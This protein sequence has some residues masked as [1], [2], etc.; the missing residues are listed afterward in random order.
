MN[1]SY[2]SVYNEAIGAWVAVSEIPRSARWGSNASGSG[3]SAEIRAHGGVKKILLALATI[4]SYS[5]TTA[6]AACTTADGGITYTCS[7]ITTTAQTLPTSTSGSTVTIDSS[8]VNSSV[9]TGSSVK[10]N[11][12]ATGDITVT[13]AQGATNYS[14]MQGIYLGS[15]TATSGNLL[16]V[17]AGN[18]TSTTNTGIT[19]Q[20][21][22]AGTTGSAVIE[23]L[24]TGVISGNTYGIVS[25]SQSTG[26]IAIKTAGSVTGTNNDG[27]MA[28]IGNAASAGTLTVNQ[29]A[30]S[31]TGNTD[32]ILVSNQGSGATTVTTAGSVAATNMSAYG[33]IN[34]SS[35]GTLTINQTGSSI[36]G[37]TGINAQAN[38]GSSGAIVVNQS[39]SGTVTGSNTGINAQS[40]GSGDISITTAG[41]VASSSSSA[42][43]AQNGASSGAIYVTQNGGAITTGRN[44]GV[45]VMAFGNGPVNVAQNAGQITG[46]ASGTGISVYNMGMASATTVTSHGDVSAG[47]GGIQVI[48]MGDVSV[49]TSGNVTGTNAYSRGVNATSYYGA[50]VVTQTSGTIT[51]GMSGINTYSTNAPTTITTAGAVNGGTYG[52]QAL[53]VGSSAVPAITINQTAGSITGTGGF[54]IYALNYAF[55]SGATFAPVALNIAGT[56]TGGT[57]PA[58]SAQPGYI[59]AGIFLDTFAGTPVTIDLQSGANVSATSGIAI[60][61]NDGDATVTFESGSKV[62][63][64]VLLGNGND[65]LTIKGTADISGATLLDGGNSTTPNVSNLLGMTIPVTDTLG[66]PTAG[67]NKL[68]F[69][70]T[71][72]SLAGSVMKNWE[73]VTL[74]GSAVTFAGDAAL[75][76]GTGTNPD[77]SLQGLVLKN[78]STLT[79]PMALAV[80]GDVAIDASS[81]LKHSV[82][83]QIT[84]NV[85]NAGLI[86]W[87][88]LGQTLTV[89]GN[90]TGISG[91]KLSLETFFG[92]DSS[93]TDKLAIDGG[94]A[95]GTT[96]L[97]IRRAGGNGAQTTQGIRVVQTL[98]GATTNPTAFTLSSL[99][100]G[101]RVGVGSIVAG[102]YDYSL[103]RGGVGGVANDWYLTSIGNQCSSNSALCPAV[104][105]GAPVA[106]KPALRPEVGSYLNNRLFAQTMQFHSLHERQGQAPGLISNNLNQGSDANVWVRL[107]G[108]TSGRSGA[109]GMDLSD[110]SYLVHAGGDVLRMKGGRDGSVRV[111]VMAAYGSGNNQASNGRLSSRGTV[112]GYNA[113]LYGT[114]YGNRDILSG[115]Y[116]DS[117][118]MFGTF[119]NKVSGQ[120]LPTE[121]YNARNLAA[122]LEGGYS[123]P[124]HDDGTNRMFLEPQAQVIVSNYRADVH[125]EQNGTVVSGQSGTSVTTRLGL[126]LHSDVKD[127]IG[128]GQMRPFAEVNWW[129]GPGSQSV[130]FDGAAIRDD[131]PANRLEG[132]VGLQGNLTKAISVWGT[133]GFEVGARDYTAGKV[134][135]GVKYSW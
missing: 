116:V 26:N 93:P 108:K 120:G 95:S 69:Q 48:G 59:G 68:T 38:P 32:G 112:D 79:S 110:T 42:I 65:T 84:G 85:T 117:W 49:T 51:A 75:V 67:T 131:L 35:N 61:K 70:G 54:G 115:P 34:A 99:S 109:D 77:G 94:N 53:V 5:A 39:T 126:R 78:A 128:M 19:V 24:S 3:A 60:Q 7:G 81:T 127:R 87:G 106:T 122:S 57:L 41:S 45:N 31:I 86:Y 29:T 66:T 30:G 13:Q 4:G 71:T 74:D 96:A 97:V 9:V 12:A 100:T 105:V 20:Q 64:Q 25:S 88:N 55:G 8:F 11:A 63:G 119:Q 90:Y 83:G 43:N 107:V 15:P 47:G 121:R 92:G 62:A 37:T 130:S 114:W 76:T 133:V 132:K 103:I 36:T 28:G 72:Q 27:V 118:L 101:Y 16:V 14:S 2:R 123:F 104:D 111:G 58:A 50:V 89:K 40:H 80:T 113:G 52:I 1:K 91:S 6:W 17:S 56:V 124:I 73:T 22:G 18:V 33:G 46:G 44:F 21:T 125:T 134:Q 10:V 98:N 129:H 102:A 82:G 23:Q 135:A